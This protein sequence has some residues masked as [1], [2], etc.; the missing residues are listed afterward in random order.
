[1][2][3]NGKAALNTS[4]PELLHMLRNLPVCCLSLMRKAM[5]PLSLF[6]APHLSS[7]RWAAEAFI[8]AHTSG[9]NRLPEEEFPKFHWIGNTCSSFLSILCR[10][11]Y[12]KLKKRKFCGKIWLFFCSFYRIYSIKRRIGVK[13]TR[14]QHIWK[15]WGMPR[16]RV[17]AGWNRDERGGGKEARKWDRAREGRGGEGRPSPHTSF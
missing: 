12:A 6:S 1:M 3:E 8:F 7:L 13:G 2:A 9:F 14:G 11:C 10:F 15:A 5:R 4:Q 16:L 17:L